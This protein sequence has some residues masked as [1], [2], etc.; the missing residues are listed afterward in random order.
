MERVMFDEVWEELKNENEESKQVFEV[1]EEVSR[2]IV[3]LIEARVD[4][5]YTQRQIAAKCGLKQ[6]AI[7]RLESI[8][9]IPRLDTI[10][11]YANALGLVINV[12]SVT[13]EMSD[14]CYADSLEIEENK[15]NYDDGIGASVKE[16]NQYGFAS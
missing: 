12:N 9:T 10:I 3:Q 2:V 16:G 15:Y 6:T 14:I 7:A 8:R 11:R 4:Q 13:A 5:G 1:A